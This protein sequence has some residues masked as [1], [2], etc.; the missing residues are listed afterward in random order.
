MQQYVD[1]VTREGISAKL[2]SSLQELDSLGPGQ[3]HRHP[4]ISK[5]FNWLVAQKRTP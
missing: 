4:S 1:R 5:V 2:S 3:L